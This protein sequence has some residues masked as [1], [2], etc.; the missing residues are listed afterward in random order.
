MPHLPRKQLNSAAPSSVIVTANCLSVGFCARVAAGRCLNY[1]DTGVPALSASVRP[2]RAGWGT[3][4]RPAVGALEVAEFLSRQGQPRHVDAQQVAQLRLHLLRTLAYAVVRHAARG[5]RGAGGGAGVAPL[6][7]PRHGAGDDAAAT[8]MRGDCIGCARAQR[9]VA[10]AAAGADQLRSCGGVQVSAAGC[11]SGRRAARV[12]GCDQARTQPA[13]PRRQRRCRDA[14]HVRQRQS[15]SAAKRRHPHHRPRQHEPLRCRQQSL[16][17]RPKHPLQAPAARTPRGCCCGPSRWTADEAPAATTTAGRARALFPSKA[18]NLVPPH[19]PPATRGDA[20]QQAAANPR[21]SWRP[22]TAPP[23]AGTRSRLAWTRSA[24]RCASLC[25]RSRAAVALAALAARERAGRRW[26]RSSPTCAPH[27][28]GCARSWRTGACRGSG[29]SRL[30]RTRAHARRTAV[31]DTATAA[32]ASRG[33]QGCQ[34]VRLLPGARRLLRPAA[35]VPSPLPASG[36]AGPPVQDD[37]ARVVRGLNGH[38]RPVHQPLPAGGRAVLRALR[39]G[40]ARGVRAVGARTHLSRSRAGTR[41][42]SR[43]APRVRS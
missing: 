3:H 11:P 35:R 17:A 23:R 29:S 39:R 40:Q 28:R 12:A 43:G 5:R 20:R 27:T 18:P 7:A 13:L 14:A 9:H 41:A 10:A 37:H 19:T 30:T 32:S 42:R 33:P 25:P 15:A 26:A 16:H 38:D 22:T 2:P 24:P 1:R 34:R 36:V 31:D 6:P 4:F 21:T 8:R